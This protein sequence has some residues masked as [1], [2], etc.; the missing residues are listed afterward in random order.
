M[1]RSRKG[2]RRKH[3]DKV[4]THSAAR[5]DQHLEREAIADTIGLGSTSS[6]VKWAALTIGGLIVAAA[7]VAFVSLV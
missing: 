5:H 1:R 7:V 6:W 2:G 4:G 3:L